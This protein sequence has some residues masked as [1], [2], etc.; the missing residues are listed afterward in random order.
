MTRIIPNE[1]F[2]K[3]AIRIALNARKNGNHA[4][5]AVVVK[6]G[7]IIAAGEQKIITE[8]DP[9][10]HAEIVAIRKAAKIIGSRHTPGCVLYTTHEP[11]S[12]CTSAAIWAKMDGIVYGASL[13]DMVDYAKKY[14]NHTYS[15][16]TI[17]I[18]AA[19]VIKK[20][21]PKLFLV[22]GFM[23]EECK[24]LFHFD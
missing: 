24:K 16:R 17:N 20:G 19:E 14:G 13:S 12:M 9:T 6:D 15:W 4:V 22:G 11:C 7:K 23:R 1:K 21:S 8:P 18:P 10:G 2:M 5:G 3:E